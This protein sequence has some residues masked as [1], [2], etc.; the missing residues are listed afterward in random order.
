MTGAGFNQTCRRAE[1]EQVA[2]D[3]A[4][5]ERLR[6]EKP[7]NKGAGGASALADGL[8]SSDAPIPF[9]SARCIIAT[10]PQQVVA[11]RQMI[12]RPIICCIVFGE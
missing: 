3:Y 6:K 9:H 4:R 11:M 2:A 5:D 1:Q 8:V 10:D 7:P 12:L